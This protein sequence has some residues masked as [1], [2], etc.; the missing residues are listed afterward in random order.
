VKTLLAPSLIG[1]APYERQ[2]ASLARAFRIVIADLDDP[3]LDFDRAAAVFER[4]RGAEKVVVLG[5]SI[6]GM[7]AIEYAR[8]F[9]H[10]VSH[11]ITVGSP[12]SGDMAALAPLGKAHFEAHASPE[13]KQILADNLA[14][15]GASPI[16]GLFA[17][18][19]LR[20]FDPRFDAAPLFEGMEMRPATMMRAMG[21]LATAWS[22]APIEVPL[23]VTLGRHDYVVPCNLWD[24]I[25]VETHIFEES[26]HQPFVEEPERFCARVETFAI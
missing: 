18:T 11:V 23:L 19:P 6:N 26:G 17:Q 1:K 16:A 2:L 22:Y 10:S 4:A 5:H 7:F 15:A 14:K 21:P 9:P 3:E 13:R 12:P 20:F 8:R 25:D 24:G